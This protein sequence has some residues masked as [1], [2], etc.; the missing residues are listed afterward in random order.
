MTDFSS[1]RDLPEPSVA[2]H[3]YTEALKH[4]RYN[5]YSN[6]LP[7]DA[8]RVKIDTKGTLLE[9]SYINANY[10]DV[11]FRQFIVSQAPVSEDIS[12]FWYMVFTNDIKSIF[13]LTSLKEGKK[14]KATR[15]WPSRGTIEFPRVGITIVPMKVDTLTPDVYITELLLIRGTTMK[16]VTHY[17]YVG[18]PDFG[19]PRT[20]HSFERM[21][22]KANSSAGVL[23]HCSAGCGR[24][25]VFCS[26]YRA[27][28][29]GETIHTAVEAVRRCRQGAVQTSSQYRFASTIVDR[30]RSLSRPP[31]PPRPLY[32]TRRSTPIRVSGSE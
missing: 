3:L 26:V 2:P 9:T 30:V 11:G 27:L 4:A 22:T 24:A 28:I 12:A 5:R 8:T 23:V 29:T 7:L 20:Y 19:V 15:Y 6:I 1:L 14:V 21:L 32:T 16:R 18:W 17:H 25:G 13:M 31:T 10:V